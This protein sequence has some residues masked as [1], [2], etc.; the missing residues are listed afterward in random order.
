MRAHNKTADNGHWIK[1]KNCGFSP[2]HFCDTYLFS[3]CVRAFICVFHF[4]QC[5]IGARVRWS[6]YPIPSSCPIDTEHGYRMH[7]GIEWT[8]KADGRHYGSLA[9]YVHN[10]K[11]WIR[12]NLAHFRCAAPT[13]NWKSIFIHFDRIIDILLKQNTIRQYNVATSTIDI[14][15]ICINMHWTIKSGYVEL[16]WLLT[17]LFIHLFHD[18]AA[19]SSYFTAP[20]ARRN[21][22]D[23]SFRC[24]N[25]H[26]GAVSLVCKIA[27]RREIECVLFGA[28]QAKTLF[29]G[30]TVNGVHFG[31][32]KISIPTQ[33]R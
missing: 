5:A 21:L 1:H 7:S 25:K 30:T 16:P 31:A 20:C 22:H 11:A 26:T 8:K 2:P 29:H 9:E 32:H 33:T 15:W 12:T 28:V 27:C 17:N 6:N 13:I 14:K 24:G 23:V 10:I 3:R 18:T 4:L 19:A